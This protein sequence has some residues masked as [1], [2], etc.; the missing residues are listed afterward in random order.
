MLHHPVEIRKIE[1]GQDSDCS[2][3]KEKVYIPEMDQ[4][5]YNLVGRLLGPRGLTL[6]Q[7]QKETNTK[8]TILGRGCMRDKAKEEEL[9]SSGDPVH[10]HLN[11][12]LHILI[13]AAPPYS[14]QKL[15]A[16]VAEVRKMLIP[17]V[18]ANFVLVATMHGI[19]NLCYGY[20][21]VLCWASEHL[22]VV[23]VV[24]NASDG[25][26]LIFK[27]ALIPWC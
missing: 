2:N 16:G 7:M 10:A 11:D 12:K 14:T 3:L 19:I 13:E 23:C 1:G 17:S 22:C 15:A 27:A 6:K 5:S 20:S 21:E 4:K 26:T 24:C 18:R 8:M 25:F 9:R